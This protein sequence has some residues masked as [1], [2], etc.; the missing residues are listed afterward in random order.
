MIK[1]FA[2]GINKRHHFH[3]ANKYGEFMNSNSDTYCSLYD[4][5]KSVIDFYAANKTLSGFDGNIY[6]PEEF[7]LDVDGPE[8]DK[9]IEKAQ[10]LSILLDQ[11]RC[12]YIIY[13]SGRG[14][15]FGIHEKAF[16]WKPD[17]N[18]HM[19]VKRELTAKGIFEY[20]DSSVTD[21]TRIIR[22]LN[23]KNTKSGL[24]KVEIK[25]DWLFHENAKELI[26]NQASAPRTPVERYII[27]KHDIIFD[28][29]KFYKEKPKPV[30]IIEMNNT[31]Y[32]PDSANY[33]CIQRMLSNTNIGE[34]HAVA[35]RVAA[36]FRWLYPES[37]VRLVMESWRQQVDKPDYRFTE[38]EMEGIIKSTYEGHGGA[39]NRYGCYDNI[40]DKFCSN[41]CRLYKAK[42]DTNTMDSK[43][44]EDSLIKFYKEDHKPIDIGA[45][46]GEK[47]PIY[48]GE[49]VILQAPPASMKTMLLQNWMVQLK[50]PTYFMEMEMSPRQIW[51]RFVMIE[52][53]WSTEELEVHYKQLR[54][55]QD[56]K[57]KWLTVDYSAP[58]ALEIEKR[59][60][61]RAVKP[62]IVVVDHL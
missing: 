3:D 19:Y 42:A 37:V 22:V 40:M 14:F 4:Y 47:F 55:G 44:M 12:K 26:T 6:I 24:F 50:R 35:L 27:T 30:S 5:D 23:T 58:Y 52:N 20:A 33:T 43:T 15:H 62:E 29:M 17:K 51:S 8:F 16:N 45:L 13:F 36:H 60:T 38:K 21:K 11:Y 56:E 46:Y 34:R 28:P 7:I 59:I 1:E 54:N 25:N 31:G 32:Q 57:F 61:M 53:N 18:L 49:V 2:F 39:G 10:K 9:A 41:K 48:P